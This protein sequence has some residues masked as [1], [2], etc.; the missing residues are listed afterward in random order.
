M[1]FPAMGFSTGTQLSTDLAVARCDPVKPIDWATGSP[2]VAGGGFV[3]RG[4]VESAR[5][6]GVV[7]KK[8]WRCGHCASERSGG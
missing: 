7:G 6:P 8:L 3:T 1:T 2:L 5:N 4:V